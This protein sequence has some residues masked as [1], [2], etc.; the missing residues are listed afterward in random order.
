MHFEYI[1]ILTILTS[2]FCLQGSREHILL[3]EYLILDVFVFIGTLSECIDLDD[4]LPIDVP[5]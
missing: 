1:L 4:F 5:V 3:C 2:S